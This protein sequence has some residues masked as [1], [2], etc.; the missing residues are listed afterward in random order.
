V[1]F[2]Y[3]FAH[4]AARAAMA[5]PSAADGGVKNQGKKRP[6]QEDAPPVAAGI[7]QAQRPYAD[8]TLRAA[9]DGTETRVHR[10]LLATHSHVLHAALEAR[11]H[12]IPGVPLG[13]VCSM[14][15]FGGS[16]CTCRTLSLPGKCGEELALLVAWLYREET[17]VYTEVHDDAGVHNTTFSYHQWRAHFAAC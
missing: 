9:A 11:Q 7:L 2:D 5:T 4:A 8:L 6:R 12:V 14:C 10:G 17:N 15:G 3:P 13:R 1:W 16:V